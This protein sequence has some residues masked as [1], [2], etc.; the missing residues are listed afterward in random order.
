VSDLRSRE[1]RLVA[2]ELGA[3]GLKGPVR[4]AREHGSKGAAPAQERPVL[5]STFCPV[6]LVTRT[7]VV[8][9]LE[10]VITEPTAQE[11]PVSGA[12]GVIATTD[13]KCRNE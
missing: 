2:T 9:L 13:D 4:C 7:R 12:L 5:I 1:W 3:P 10:P 8:T 11:R 6:I